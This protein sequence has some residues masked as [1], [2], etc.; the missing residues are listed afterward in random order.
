MAM[1]KYVGNEQNL[2][3]AKKNTTETW[4]NIIEGHTLVNAIE[5]LLPLAKPE[6]LRVKRNTRENDS[7]A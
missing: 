4:N 3:T 7:R 5:D 1:G 2:F 6:K